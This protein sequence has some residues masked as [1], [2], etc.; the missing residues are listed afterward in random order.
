MRTSSLRS[1]L[2]PTQ[3]FGAIRES[4]RP[5]TALEKLRQRA[6]WLRLARRIEIQ[7]QPGLTRLGSAYGGYVVP[8]A[9]VDAD[10][11]CY[12][13]G[14]GEDI[15]FELELIAATR[16]RMYGF[17][18]TP[19]AVAHAQSVAAQNPQFRFMPVGLW[20]SDTTAC[21]YEP[22]DSRHASYSIAGLQGTDGYIT[23][24]C[25][26]LTSLMSELQHDRIDL[27]KLDVEGAEYE[28]LK[29][30][31]RGDLKVRV[32]CVD[33]HKVESIDHMARTVEQLASVGYR[34][35]HVHRTDVTMIRS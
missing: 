1:V 35:V 7:P 11:I 17:D 29:P 22:A 25:R 34:P 6:D 20:S 15:S 3:G 31:F 13:G 21:F 4:L 23:A 2:G 12:S 28:V 32:L 5:R 33:F 26:S 10:W 27:L 14:L 9:L 16:C 18:P 19:R 8:L 30:L 24:A